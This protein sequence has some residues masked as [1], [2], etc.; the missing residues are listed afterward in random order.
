MDDVASDKVFLAVP[1]YDGRVTIQTLTGVVYASRRPA[2]VACHT[3]SL[4]AHGFNMLWCAALS[5]GANIWAMLHADIGPDRYWVDTLLDEMDL[6][7]AD[8]I[9][10]VVPIK[11]DDHQYSVA[12]GRDQ[13]AP[14]YRL[15]HEHL[16]QLPRTFGADDLSRVSGQEGMLLANTGCWVC[17]LDR[18][19]VRQ[20]HYEIISQ[21]DWTDPEK[22]RP[23]VISEDWGFSM[24]VQRLG[25][26]V[27]C[28]RAVGVQHIGERSWSLPA[29]QS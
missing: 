4:L 20:V 14:T 16:E 12:I 27:L 17:R 13:C 2:A 25:G 5:S 3:S 1:T 19:W 18:P 29:W 24:Q 8:L 9:S 21:I 22:P 28:T 26:R 10:A 7:D 23:L 11:N 15:T 6:H